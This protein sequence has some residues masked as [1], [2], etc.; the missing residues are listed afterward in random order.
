MTRERQRWPDLT[1]IYGGKECSSTTVYVLFH[2]YLSVQVI[3]IV[4]D[5][6]MTVK[7]RTA[8]KPLLLYFNVCLSWLGLWCLTSLSTIFLLFHDGQFY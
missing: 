4:E 6:T 5:P 3:L 8:I 7:C 2:A 1:F